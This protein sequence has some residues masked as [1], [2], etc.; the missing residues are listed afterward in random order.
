MSVNSKDY[1]FE[2]FVI[3]DLRKND[4]HQ[5]H[6][7]N[8]KSAV[9]LFGSLDGSGSKMPTLGV[10]VG[11]GSLDLIHRLNGENVLV[12]DYKNEQALS[13]DV[14]AAINEIEAVAK[15]LIN[16]GAVRY[17]YSN[18][19][20]PWRDY[21][22]KV[23]API[24]PDFVPDAY[25][26]DKILK[27]GGGIPATAINEIY[28][29]GDGW[30]NYKDFLKDPSQYVE[31]GVLKV[32][33]V[34]VAY[35]KSDRLVGVDGQMDLSVDNFEA[36]AEKL[37]KAY[38]ISV[39]DVEN[40]RYE[41][42]NFAVASFDT[43]PEAVK[44]WYEVNE[45]TEHTPGVVSKAE[46]CC[47]FN[48]CNENLE[49][50]SYETA[51]KIY[52]FELDEEISNNNGLRVET[53]KP[54]ERSYT[55]RQSEGINNEA[56]LI[57][58]IRAD[59]GSGKEFWTTWNEFSSSRKTSEFS[60]ELD[61]VINALRFDEKY[62][63]ILKDRDSLARYCW[64]HRDAAYEDGR[65]NYGVRVDTDKFS[66]LLR[67]NPNQG[68]YNLYCYCYEKDLLNEHLHNAE[69]V[70]DVDKLINNAIEA[71]KTA[72]GDGKVKDNIQLEKE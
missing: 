8:L 70:A 39:P 37:N 16:E 69:K 13:A 22:V 11:S 17:R 43:L 41:R 30:V 61:E 51:S 33:S 62:N 47:V 55:F 50:I 31:N 23:I 4:F 57:G 67:L 71:S 12:S 66:Y 68:D 14:K 21:S 72:E 20:L 3:D 58:F 60:K 65:N 36:M 28:L 34:N 40:S 56:G 63:G 59:F 25:C 9:E 44:A 5:E 49:E 38:F 10:R 48:G 18:V 19:I 7:D 32:E 15:E 46:G 52:G 64:S 1:D 24:V 26:N 2:F 29:D 27:A 6:F 45:K 53:I 35:V 42:S 54:E